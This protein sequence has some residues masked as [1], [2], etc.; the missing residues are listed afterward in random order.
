MKA[1]INL[2]KL[3]NTLHSWQMKGRKKNTLNLNHTSEQYDLAPT[4]DSLVVSLSKCFEDIFKVN[5]IEP[6]R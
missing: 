2:D 5:C 1:Y 4:Q 3:E 6:G